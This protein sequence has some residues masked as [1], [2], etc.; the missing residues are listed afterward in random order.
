MICSLRY[1]SILL[2]NESVRYLKEK[3]ITFVQNVEECM[4]QILLVIS[5]SKGYMLQI[6]SEKWLSIRSKL[7]GQTIYS[8]VLLS[9]P[10]MIARQ[11]RFPPQDG[12]LV[13]Q[14]LTADG[15]LETLSKHEYDLLTQISHELRLDG[16]HILN[17]E[18]CMMA[19]GNLSD[20]LQDSKKESSKIN[21]SLRKPAYQRK[22]AV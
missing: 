16:T 18:E 4:Q 9:F 1:L 5:K 19:Y 15:K 3:M 17:L 22:Q 12:T 10:S 21:D 8:E 14:C 7:Q 2:M 11:D 20:T 6:I 13:I